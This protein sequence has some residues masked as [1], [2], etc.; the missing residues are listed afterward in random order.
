[1]ND[2]RAPGEPADVPRFSPGCG[3]VLTAVALVLW[4]IG[5][6]LLE[7]GW[8]AATGKSQVSLAGAGVEFVYT[9][10]FVLLFWLAFRADNPL[11]STGLAFTRRFHT[12]WILG[13]IIGGAGVAVALI[14]IDIGGEVST[15]S[16]AVSQKGGDHEGPFSWP[17]AI[18]ILAL[19]AGEEE[20]L[21]RGLV[22]PLLR[23]SI[24]LIW[25]V[26]ISSLLF[27]L[28]HAFNNAFSWI[29]FLDIILAGAS[30]ALLR[31]L[32]G[33]LWLAWGA[34]FGWNFSLAAL[35]LPVSGILVLLNPQSWHVV[36]LGPRFLTG[37]G[38]GPEGGMG[39]IIADLCM[40][41][42][43]AFLLH[44]KGKRRKIEEADPRSGG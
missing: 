42:L 34:H 27:S 23:R 7:L 36:T 21:Y 13:V 8:E 39:G 5:I 24:G 16:G 41:G 25:A 3:C 43:A 30:L 26:A 22:Y 28:L 19:Y 10:A 4:L 29:P 44:L 18:L 6:V 31:E 11:R 9:G 38:F 32:T 2:E 1:M 20:I 37:G 12:D 35:G 15:I 40:I 14:A 17:I 33:S